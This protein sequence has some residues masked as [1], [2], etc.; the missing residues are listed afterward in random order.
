[1]HNK[2]IQINSLTLQEDWNRGASLAFGGLRGLLF[3][4]IGNIVIVIVVVARVVAETAALVV[5][6]LFAAHG[7]G[8]LGEG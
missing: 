1:M 3:T 6:G 7:G 8:R 4:D 2:H 5:V